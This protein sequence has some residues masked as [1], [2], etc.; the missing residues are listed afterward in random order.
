M[1]RY[2]RKI[3][4]N[5]NLFLLQAQSSTA[6]SIVLMGRGAGLI[7]ASDNGGESPDDFDR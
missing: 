3:F 7:L 6:G 1:A 4:K 2:F 5:P